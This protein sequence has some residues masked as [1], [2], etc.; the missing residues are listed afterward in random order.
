M[1]LTAD[2]VVV[3]LEAKTSRYNA[4]IDNS[5]RRFDRNMDRV[6]R[7]VNSAER[8]VRT[9]ASGM[10]SAMRTALATIG[11]TIAVREVGQLADAY[12][13]AGNKV[14][15]A[16][17]IFKGQLA[18]QGELADLAKTTRSEFAATADLYSRLAR[19]GADL[20]LMQQQL[21]RTTELLNKAFVAGGSGT[22]ERRS[23]VL[24]L[25]QAL[26]SGELLGEE[27]RAIRENAPLVAQAIADEFGVGIGQLKELGRQGELTSDRIVKAILGASAG[28]ETAFA[29][30]DKTIGDSLTNLR[31]EAIRFVGELDDATRATEGLTKFIGYAADNM[32]TFADAAVVATAALGGAFA[33]RAVLAATT[34]LVALS[35]SLGS[36]TAGFTAYTAASL[37]AARATTALKGAMAFFGGP[38]GIAIAAVAGSV[39]LLSKR[40][41]DAEK[42]LA[43]QRREIERNGEAADLLVEKVKE[44]GSDGAEAI[45]ETG[46]EAETAAPKVEKF[47]GE[48]GEAAQKLYE[49]ADARKGASLSELT[50]SGLQARIDIADLN[51]QVEE[52]QGKLKFFERASLGIDTPIVK[53]TERQI[54]DLKGQI[55][56]RRADIDAIEAEFDRVNDLGAEAFSRDDD[57][58]RLGSDGDTD[59]P[60]G[61]SPEDIARLRE[62]LELENQLALAEASGDEMAIRAAERKLELAR[63]TADFES[64]GYANARERANAQMEA[65]SA[66]EYAARARQSE[67]DFAEIL[68]QVEEEI[69]NTK[70]E[71]LDY[72]LELARLRGDETAIQR[73]EREL[74]ILREIARL[75]GQGVDYERA[76]SQATGS[77]N[78]RAAA[79]REGEETRELESQRAEFRQFFRDSFKDGILAGLD[80]NAGEALSN[81]WRTYTTR[82]LESVLNNLADSLFDSLIGG[83]GKGFFGSLFGGFRAS[84]GPVSAGKAYVV[85]EKRPEMFVPGQSGTIIPKIPEAMSGGSGGGVSVYVDGSFIVQGNVTEDSLPALRQEVAAHSAALRNIGPTIDQ[86]VRDSIRRR[87]L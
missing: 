58:N 49:L 15:A 68:L 37:A 35:A 16:E 46:K 70:I 86:R 18:T 63:L 81:W 3:T 38:I 26:A 73:L 50:F 47:A 45:K 31:T 11:V 67:K 75:R 33:A 10:S 24:Q 22:A 2:K 48:V 6:K 5:R 53:Q 64:A 9:S 44:Y 19:A 17:T 32:E 36:A 7:S 4:E 40:A 74:E 66:A 1:A 23:T 85:G 65:V 14:A 56:N 71:Q 76:R 54:E 79:R 41:L 34:S 62:M 51:R 39:A 61:P 43:D 42:A 12:T 21:L 27:L 83:A 69:R 78:E 8:E 20:D 25:S 52:Y 82:A 60:K 87:K 29:A 80:E 30:T 72:E 55:A 13:E 28:I 84:G 57:K 77:A 59:K